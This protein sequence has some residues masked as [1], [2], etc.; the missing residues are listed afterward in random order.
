MDTVPILRKPS[1]VRL[2][3]GFPVSMITSILGEE[4]EPAST[5]LG[6]SHT[7][8][9]LSFVLSRGLSTNEGGSIRGDG[10]AE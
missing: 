7:R 6:I 5:L 8:S 10:E 9:L 1:T 4:M 3:K 2:R